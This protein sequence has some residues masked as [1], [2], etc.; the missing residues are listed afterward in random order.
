MMEF[1]LNVAFTQQQLQMLYATGTNVVVAKPTGGYNPNV[2]WQVIRPM[3]SNKLTWKEEY[4]IYVSS[5]NVQNGATLYQLSSVP[6]GALMNKL[7]TFEPNAFISG[8]NSGGVQGGFALNNM[9]LG[10]PYM[11]AGLYQDATVNG[12]DIIGNAISATPVLMQSTVVM[13]PDT[14]LYIWLQSQITGNM[15][16]TRITSPMT[17]LSFGGSVPEISVAYD[18]NSGTFVPNG[19]KKLASSDETIQHIPASL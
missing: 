8:P 3:Q 18:S 4:G 2:A 6:V 9:Y 17:R 12:T 15:V 11:T 14:T 5:T 19:A 13:T 16:V 7:Y 1:T 10:K